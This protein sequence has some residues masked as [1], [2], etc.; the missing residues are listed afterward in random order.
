MN[1]E[2]QQKD[3]QLSDTALCHQLYRHFKASDGHKTEK[4]MACTN[5]MIT[6]PSSERPRST[7]LYSTLS[8]SALRQKKICN[9]SKKE[10]KVKPHEILPMFSNMWNAPSNS[11]L[12]RYDSL[13]EKWLLCNSSNIITFKNRSKN[14]QIV[15]RRNNISNKTTTTAKCKHINPVRTFTLPWR[16]LRGNH[17][18]D[19]ECAYCISLPRR[20]AQTLPE[21]S[22]L[23]KWWSIYQLSILVLKLAMNIS[24][25]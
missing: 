20:L 24:T 23:Q 14:E 10:W 6:P 18:W 3:K 5:K 16:H 9:L 13:P 1:N 7:P 11:T 4:I 22:I 8:L 12:I 19:K 17:T 21:A 15:K 25:I 2:Y